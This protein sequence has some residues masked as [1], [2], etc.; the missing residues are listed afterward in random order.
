M[1][2]RERL[3][4]D[5]KS[6]MKAGQADKVG[7]LRLVTSALR[8]EEIKKG[9]EL[10]DDEV[11]KIFASE[12][13]KRQDSIEA[14]QKGGRQDLADKEKHE[15][16]L[17]QQYLP[18]QMSEE[19][20]EKAVE[21]ILATLRQAQGDASFGSVMKAVTAELKGKADSRLI[22]EIVKKKLR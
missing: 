20:V 4:E 10:G 11:L 17:L 14:F 2:L 3:S 13:K 16:E 19:E 15:L 9:K 5:L 22:S 1:S 18:K 8:N 6:S 7:L 21:K 12:A